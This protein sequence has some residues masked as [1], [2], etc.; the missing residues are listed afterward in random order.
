MKSCIN[1]VSNCFNT[2]EFIALSYFLTSQGERSFSAAVRITWS[3]IRFPK[4]T[5]LRLGLTGVLTFAQVTLGKAN[6]PNAVI[7]SCLA[8]RSGFELPRIAQKTLGTSW[9]NKV[10]GNLN[11]NWRIW[12][13]PHKRTL[14]LAEI[15]KCCSCMFMHGQVFAIPPVRAQK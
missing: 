15:R 4:K 3:K 12:L 10:P 11:K 13:Y 7:W 1:H 14:W 2:P 8:M 6:P 9:H 5:F